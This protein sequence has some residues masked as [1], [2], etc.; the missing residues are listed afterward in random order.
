MSLLQAIILGIVQGITEFLPISSSGHLI[1]AEEL[2]NL[3]VANLKSFD[4]TVHLGTLL[5]IFCYFYRDFVL[6]LRTFFLTINKR[7]PFPHDLKS[8]QNLLVALII[9]TIPAVIIGLFFENL[10][11]QYTR[12]ITT[13]AIFMGLSGIIF[14]LTETRQKP[15]PKNFQDSSKEIRSR[16]ALII[17]I[18]Q[19]IA[20]LPG[21]SRSGSTISAALFVGIRRELAARFSF[22]LGAIAIAGAGILT[23]A[24]LIAHPEQLIS[25]QIYLA[26]FLASFLAGYLSISGLMRYLKHHDLKIFGIY[27]IAISLIISIFSFL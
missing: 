19:A 23:S 5:A 22:L 11:D 14:F 4:I 2:L 25:P 13:V 16:S 17:G 20:I 21:I 9:G 27:L 24:K 7:R 3:P 15:P 12:N 18:S 1:I 6:L 26:G 8:Y 10:I